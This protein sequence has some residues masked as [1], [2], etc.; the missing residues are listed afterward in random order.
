MPAPDTA[1][2]TVL[3]TDSMH[4]EIS[5]RQPRYYSDA[6]EVDSERD[7]IYLQ[8]ISLVPQR[9]FKHDDSDE[10]TTLIIRW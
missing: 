2:H 10:P 7:Q 5:G 4:M 8:K 1:V 3:L 6:T 9:P